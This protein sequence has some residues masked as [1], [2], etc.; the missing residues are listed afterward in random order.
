MGAGFARERLT[1]DSIRHLRA[2]SAFICS[3]DERPFVPE[4]AWAY[5]SA[6]T[7]VLIFNLVRFKVLKVDIENPQRL[8]KAE[9]VRSIL[10]AALPHQ[11]QF[12]DGQDVGAYYYLLDEI[13]GKL[14]SELRKILD[15]KD[16]DQAATQRAKEIMS[17]IKEVDADQARGKLSGDLPTN[18]PTGRY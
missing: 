16:A 5:F 4:I 17:A 10:K 9:N 14:L 2:F 11:A 3:R 1:T 8:L 7:T 15:G 13:E 6:F 18:S 12:I